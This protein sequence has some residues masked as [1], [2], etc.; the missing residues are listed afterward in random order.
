LHRDVWEFHHGPIPD[1]CHIHHKD[2]NHLNND[3][4]NLECIT[5]ERHEELHS[6]GRSKFGRSEAQIQHLA[7]I[8]QKASDWHRSEEGRRWH[9]EHGKSAWAARTTVAL[10]CQECGAGF[11]S[12]RTSASFCSAKCYGKY[13]LI[14]KDEQWIGA[15]RNGILAF[16]APAATGKAG[17]ETPNGMFHID[18]RHRNHTSSLYKIE[19][20]GEQY[21]MD[22]ALRFFIDEKLV[23]YWV[24]ARDLPG[25][26]ASHGC[27][28]LFDEGMQKRMFG[29]PE[30]PVLL[31]SQKLYAWA[32]PESTFGVDTGEA[33]E[34]TGGPV[35]EVRG[36]LPRYR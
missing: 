32:V 2:G 10:I 28:G 7:A 8:R 33:Q 24:H 30:R 22:N 31:D 27:I 34:I 29:V 35:L 26:P 17:T 19:D 12:L 25:R 11:E 1:G 16:S 14:D 15:Y 13:L 20:E 21:P 18:A 5:R 23:G 36:T 6:A 3:I 9:V 4:Q